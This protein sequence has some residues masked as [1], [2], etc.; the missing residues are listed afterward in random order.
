MPDV[1]LITTL[2][3]KAEEAN[4]LS[5]RLAGHG[6]TTH[7]IDASLASGGVIL[8]GTAKASAIAGAIERTLEA[9]ET[10]MGDGIRAVVGL[11]GGTGAEIILKVM[12]GLPITFP[13][14]LVTTL[15]FDPRIA[16]ADNS[17]ILVPTL[18]D[19][20]GLNAT[21]RE[22]LENAAAMTA[23]LCH[24]RRQA[25][26]CVD[27]PSIAITALGA[28]E[29]AVVQLNSALK[30]RGEE[31]TI[32][33]ANGYGGAAFT[34]FARRGAFDAIVDLTPHEATR[35][36]IAGAHVPMPDRFSSAPDLP[37]I[38][39]PGAVNFIGLGEIA[40]VPPTYL[41]RPHYQHSGYFTH[42]KLNA[43]EM[44]RVASIL[45]ESLNAV[46]G[47]SAM[48]V[49]MGGFSHQDRPGGAIEDPT[50][51]GVF[52]ET[53]KGVLNP[54]VQ[55]QTLDAHLFDPEVTESIL[56]TLAGLTASK[57]I[58]HA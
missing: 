30:D 21:L 5:G 38:V 54:K 40:L 14:V 33:H 22:V 15:P 56:D 49:P 53:V 24:S 27:N 42:V 18:A 32:F 46:A 47:P 55:L 41:E 45:A 50:L 19:I 3:T 6:V 1:L 52:L 25:N 58:A 31:A 4:Y 57:D 34:R 11:G 43:D 10:A 39:L 29:A 17:I 51:R 36:H 12:R 23:G 2:E 7:M 20:C 13:K 35:L 28:T 37:R 8:G 26:A 44:V 9:V 16:L 48:I